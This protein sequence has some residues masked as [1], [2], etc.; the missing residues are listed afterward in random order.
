M[1]RFRNHLVY[2]KARQL[3]AFT[4]FGPLCH[5]DLYFIG[6]HQILRCYAETSRSYL[7]DG[8][9]Q[10][11]SVFA[12]RKACAVFASL[13][14]VAAS[15]NP[16]HGNGHCLMR[17]F[18]DRPVTHGTRHKAVHD[19]FYRFNLIY[20]NGGTAEIQEVAQEDRRFFSVY[21]TGEFFE[22]LIAAQACGKLQ[23]RNGFGVPGMFFS[24]FTESIQ[25]V[26]G[27]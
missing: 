17:F 4:R 9:T 1:A 14:C 3:T 21:Q 8:A 6:I 7:L 16:V 20:R 12:G 2:F 5:F 23:G 11:G 18:A 26:V 25:T 27:E 22:L 15:V 10:T 19:A 13:T 24:V